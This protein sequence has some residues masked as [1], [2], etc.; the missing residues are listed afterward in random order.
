LIHTEN[1][2]IHSKQKD[3]IPETEA[4]ITIVIT[5]DKNH[6]LC[7]KINT[8]NLYQ[9]LLAS[10]RNLASISLLGAYFGKLDGSQGTGSDVKNCKKMGK[11]QKG[12]ITC[13][14]AG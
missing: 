2:Q 9:Y 4:T 12:R 1:F 3:S 7:L 8:V 14:L 6:C 5:T 10:S 11:Y 13:L